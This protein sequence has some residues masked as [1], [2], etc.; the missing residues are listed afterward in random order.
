MKRYIEIESYEPSIDT[1][2]I[3]SSYPGP[4][5]YKTSTGLA[6]VYGTTPCVA[7]A[8]VHPMPKI[9][10]ADLDQKP[11]SGV[12]VHRLFDQLIELKK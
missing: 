5:I 12:D 2:W 9:I 4:G 3:A 1:E 8:T 11:A 10:E 6:M 7:M